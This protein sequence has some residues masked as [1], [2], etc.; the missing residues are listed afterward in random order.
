MDMIASTA[1]GSSRLPLRAGVGLK[2][3]HYDAILDPE[4]PSGRPS[5]VE[6]HPQNYFCDG[7]PPHRWLSAI[8]EILPISFHSVG[9]SLGSADGLNTGDL[10]KLAALCERYRPAMV[11]DH[12]S[13]SGNAHD[14]FA[15]LF[16]VPHTQE[17]LDHFAA[18]VDRVQQRLGRQMLIENPS[19]YLAYRD[20]QMSEVAFL[21]ELI[22]RTGCGL[23]LDINNIV[24]TTGNLGGAAEDYLSAIDPDWVGE[25]HLAGH[26]TELH[27]SGPLY[28]DDHGSTVSARVWELYGAFIQR[29]GPKPTLI[30]W[31]TDVPDYAILMAE[32][33]KAD[34]ELREP[35]HAFA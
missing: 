25:I 6:V 34:A 15:D 16:P 27:D 9:L 20:S 23:L 21:A 19:C 5:W 31:D 11:S 22:Q 12:L 3:Q 30:E 4:H 24:V 1:R 35:A 10:E 18:Q 32:A 13:F 14:R 26:A 17:S 28:I 2:P 8:A 7:G 33:G 29:A